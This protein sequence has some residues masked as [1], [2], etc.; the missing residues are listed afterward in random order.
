M[1]FIGCK[2]W[3]E[4]VSL[5]DIS[6]VEP[7]DP[8]IVSALPGHDGVTEGNAIWRDGDTYR[9]LSARRGEYEDTQTLD[10][11]E[12]L[13]RM[14]RWSV[15]AVFGSNPG[16][17]HPLREDLLGAAMF[18]EA[19]SLAER[20]GARIAWRV[21]RMTCS[22]DVTNTA[23]VA[24]Y[25]DFSMAVD[26][27]RASML[28]ED[29][30]DAPEC[31]DGPGFWGVEVTLCRRRLPP[32]LLPYATGEAVPPERPR[33]FW[34]ENADYERE[35]SVTVPGRGEVRFIGAGAKEV[36]AAFFLRLPLAKI[37]MDDRH[38]ADDCRDIVAMPQAA[39][40]VL[41][42]RC[43]GQNGTAHASGPD[44]ESLASEVLD[45]IACTAADATTGNAAPDWSA[46]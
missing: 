44:A 38:A 17:S 2:S 36:S 19:V 18:A 35:V 10:T 5:A 20:T 16:V 39:G 14:L 30:Q 29:A 31:W 41:S 46:S 23:V 1:E 6:V 33:L 22:C 21:T 42:W 37:S 7:S 27:M 32:H 25:D 45:S 28:H 12:A 26:H 15:Q 9:W 24:V 43:M 13:E 40:A 8:V 4:F 34:R 11:D 3:S